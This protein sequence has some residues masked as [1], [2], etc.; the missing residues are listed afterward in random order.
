MQKKLK[1]NNME[2]IEALKYICD[3]YDGS[4]GAFQ[5]ACLRDVIQEE[6]EEYYLEELDDL[7]REMTDW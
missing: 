7:I 3:K 4:D 6:Q 1:L 5:F 2:K